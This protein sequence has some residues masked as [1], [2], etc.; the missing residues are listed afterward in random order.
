MGLRQLTHKNKAIERIRGWVRW[1]MPIIPALWEADVGPECRTISKEGHRC[2]EQP[3]MRGSTPC[4]PSLRPLAA[5]GPAQHF[6]RPRQA[7]HL[8]SGVQDQPG[9]H[10]ETLS[11]LKVQNY[12]GMVAHACNPSYMGGRLRPENRLNPGGGGCRTTFIRLSS[13]VTQTLV[14]YPSLTK[15]TSFIPVP[16]TMALSYKSHFSLPS[17]FGGDGVSLCCLRW[18]A[19]V[20]SW[21]TATSA[22]RVQARRS[23]H[24]CNCSALGG[25][26]GQITGGE[27]FEISQANML[28]WRLRQEKHLNS[29][30][31]GCSEPRSHHCTPAWATEQDSVSKKQTKKTQFSVLNTVF[32]HVGQAGLE[33]LTSSDLPASAF[34]SAR[35]TGTS[36]HARSDILNFA[37]LECISLFGFKYFFITGSLA[38]LP[39]LECSG[40]ILAHCDLHLLDSTDSLASAPDRWDFS[41]LVRLV[42]NSRPQVIRLPEPPKV[43]GL[44]A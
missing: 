41:M 18:S 37:Y 9:Q 11:L 4:T 28:L 24:A 7:D 17:F 21:L 42:S 27:E 20:Q 13:W 15:N 39:R 38:L 30:G 23:A 19:V 31:G 16:R 32:H 1:L 29:G 6:E 26:G 12:L 22:S 5:P 34:L 2:P 8:R 44:Q 25:Q 14:K 40:V 35:I 43:L 3:Y 10:G 33:L 36:H